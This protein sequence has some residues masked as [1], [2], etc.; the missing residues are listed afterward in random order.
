MVTPRRGLTRELY[1]SA[2]ESLESFAEQS[3][4]GDGHSKRSPDN[5]RPLPYDSHGRQSRADD[6][7][8]QESLEEGATG[9]SLPMFGY[10]NAW[11]DP[12]RSDFRFALFSGPHGRGISVGDYGST[13]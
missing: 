10:K 9:G 3:I 12:Q 8:S 1:A 4:A 13:S 2:E 11:G 6:E 5:D 7:S